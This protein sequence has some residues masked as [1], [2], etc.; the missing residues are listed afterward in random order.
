MKA[1][2]YVHHDG[3]TNSDIEGTTRKE[4][5]KPRKDY[6]SM[7]YSDVY[8]MKKFTGPG[9]ATRGKLNNY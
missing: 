9:A 4:R 7:D 8:M 1:P 2:A 3:L 6:N 5:F